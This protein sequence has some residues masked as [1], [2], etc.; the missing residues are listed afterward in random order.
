MSA[1]ERR[2]YSMAEASAVEEEALTTLMAYLADRPGTLEVADVRADSFFRAVD[3]D[4][5]W[6]WRGASGE[7]HTTWLEVKADRWHQTGNFFFETVSN[8]ARGTPGCFLYTEADYL[9]YYFVT[10]RNAYLLPL[11]ATRD[12]FL[13]Q[14]ARFAERETSTPVGNGEH[15]VTVGR[16]VPIAEVLEQ[17]PGVR[18]RQL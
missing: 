10:P 3:V 6:T 13:A 8:K 17:V 18:Q 4:L 2:S 15:Y 16:L 1:N 14:R 7:D 12:W 9:L 11:P 5:L